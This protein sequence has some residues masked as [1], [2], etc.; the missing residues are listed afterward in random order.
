MS[1]MRGKFV[2]APNGDQLVPSNCLSGCT[3]VV[4]ISGSPF[5]GV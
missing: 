2:L 5:R 4:R 1:A 3:G